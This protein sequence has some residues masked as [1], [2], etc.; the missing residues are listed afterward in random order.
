MTRV[1]SLL[2]IGA[3]AT[4]TGCASIVSDSEYPVAIKSVPAGAAFEVTGPGGQVV[5]SGTTPQTVTLKSG[6]GYFGS[7]TYVIKFKKD[8]FT[9]Q[10][11]TLDSSMDGWFW[12]NIIFGGLIGMLIVDPITG[13]MWKLPENAEVTLAEIAP[14]TEPVVEKASDAPQTAEPVEAVPSEGADKLKASEP[15][16]KPEDTVSV[17]TIDQVPPALRPHLVRI[18]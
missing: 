13:A 17:I 9:E 16:P 14:P 5:H 3:I 12:G 1:F 6:D 11:F 7:A 15:A 2:G 18:N 8:N 4:L 10:T